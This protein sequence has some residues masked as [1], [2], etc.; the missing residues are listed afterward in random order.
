MSVALKRMRHCATCSC[1]F[2]ERQRARFEIMA[3]ADL[4]GTNYTS[5]LGH[6]RTDSVAVRRHAVIAAYRRLH[7]D[8]SWPV[9]GRY[10]DRDHSTIIHAV[11]TART[12]LVDE[13][14]ARYLQV[15]ADKPGIQRVA[16]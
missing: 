13:L 15:V 12:V 6:L 7:P 3:L 1:N 4:M 9:I 2:E 5:V 14:V 11:K 10:F 8:M 16:G